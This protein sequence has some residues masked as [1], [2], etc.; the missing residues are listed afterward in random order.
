VAA[1]ELYASNKTYLRVEKDVGMGFQPYHTHQRSNLESQPSLDPCGNMLVWD[2][3]LDNFHELIKQLNLPDTEA[4]DSQIVL[5]AFRRWGDEC[6]GRFVGDWALALWSHQDRSVYLARDHAGTRTLYFEQTADRVLWSTYLEAFFA[7]G[8]T[9]ELNREYAACYLTGS[10]LRDRTP[11]KDI[12]AV[13]PAH[14]LR[15]RGDGIIRRAHWQWMVQDRIRYSSAETYGDHFLELFRHSVARRTGPGAPILAE[16]SGGMD[17]SSIVCMSD[18]LRLPHQGG[19][20]REIFDTKSLFDDS[21]PAWDEK[22][23]FAIVERQRGKTGTHIDVSRCEKSYEPLALSQGRLPLL[24]GLDSGTLAFQEEMEGQLGYDHRVLLSGIG[25][26]E[27][28]GGVPSGVPEL[29]DLLIAGELGSL[30]RRA[31]AWC[32]VDR[33]P[34]MAML[35]RTSQ[36]A[37]GVHQRASGRTEQLPDWIPVQVG[38]LASNTGFPNL[39]RLRRI[40]MSPSAIDNG[41]TWWT[42]LESQPHLFPSYSIRREYRYPYLDRE[43]VEFLFRVPRHIL[44]NPGRRRAMMRSALK[45]I[46]P[47]EI[48]ERRRKAYVIRKHLSSMAAQQEKLQGLLLKPRLADYGLVAPARLVSALNAVVGVD[49]A[50]AIDAANKIKLSKIRVSRTGNRGLLACEVFSHSVYGRAVACLPVRAGNLDEC[51]EAICRV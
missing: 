50:D 22:P 40:G 34:L 36:F 30:L 5:A 9:R 39:H 33:S 38:Q 28:L 3:R 24:P 48:L 31:V 45:N 12:C 15:I 37:V 8:K 2:G 29:A 43:L 7:E 32:L 27:L 26:D 14:Y 13:P 17:S 49:C 51:L 35:F 18:T 23:Y 19:S 6:L 21:E 42:I 25:G 47:V 44:L 20:S 4:P 16:L 1:A 10:P 41:L 46:V 11:Y